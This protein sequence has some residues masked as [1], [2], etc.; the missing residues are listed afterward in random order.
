MDLKSITIWTFIFFIFFN[1]FFDNF[2]FFMIE[3]IGTK[4]I[5]LGIWPSESI[6]WFPFFLFNIY[7]YFLL[8]FP[9]AFS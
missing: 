6:L 4:I 1:N 8:Y 3:F 9:G 2:L 5:Y 7:V